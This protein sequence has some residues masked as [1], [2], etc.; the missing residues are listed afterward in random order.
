VPG[1]YEEHMARKVRERMEMMK[2]LLGAGEWLA[3][4]PEEQ[5]TITDLER[6][7]LNFAP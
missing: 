2:V 7:R 3:A 6:Y 1:T 5:D 4:S